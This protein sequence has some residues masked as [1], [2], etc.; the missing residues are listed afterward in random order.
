MDIFRGKDVLAMDKEQIS[1]G[2]DSLELMENAA[3]AIVEVAAEHFSSMID[4]K[5]AVF[6]GHGNNGGDGIAAA[7]LLADSGAQVRCFHVGNGTFSKDAAEMAKRFAEAGGKVEIFDPASRDIVDFCSKADLLVDAIFGVGFKGKLEG[8]F[9]EAARM[10]NWAPGYVIS[11]DLPSGCQADT[12][13]ASPESVKADVT[14][15]FTGLK[16]VHAVQ[17]AKSFCGKVK[18]YGIGISDEIVRKYAPLAELVG[19]DF[20]DRVIPKRQANTHKGDYGKLLVVGGSVGYTGAPYMAAQAAART[21]TGMV[22]LAVP[23]SIYSIEAGR[24]EE[25]ICLPMPS[26]G[27]KF[28]TKALSAVLQLAGKCDVCLIGPG[29]G[30][31]KESDKFICDIIAGIKIPVVIDADGINAVSENINIL[32]SRTAPAVL[33]PHDIEF[34]RLGGN[35]SA[36]GRIDAAYRMAGDL[37]VTVVL[38][39]NTTVIADGK[40]AVYINTTGNPG[41]ARGGS[42]DVLAGVIAALIAQGISCGDAA[43]AGVYLHGAAGDICADSIGEYGMLPSDII[44]ALPQMLK[45]YNSK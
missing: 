41:M 2:T 39:G 31:S 6:C 45:K 16:A 3:N 20:L 22:Y 42:G 44:S 30:R 21:G 38:K 29:I 17:P 26:V 18:L 7:R 13:L 9:L 33:T 27:G 37:G 24:C 25:I 36:F 8:K 40:E 34:K 19:S 5:A 32:R 4:I 23:E 12:A 43:A 11:A 35:I 28:S 15:T 1:S 14:V 10:I